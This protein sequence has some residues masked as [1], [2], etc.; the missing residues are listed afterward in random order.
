MGKAGN[1]EYFHPEKRQIG[2]A[3][4]F[5]S[6]AL[7]PAMPRRVSPNLV[8][9]HSEDAILGATPTVITDD[10]YREPGDRKAE[11]LIVDAQPKRNT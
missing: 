5:I 2:A 11:F 10:D 9:N 1:L 6:S 4:Q 3:A 7:T 8:A